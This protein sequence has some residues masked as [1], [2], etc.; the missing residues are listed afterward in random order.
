MMIFLSQVSVIIE[1]EIRTSTYPTRIMLGGRFEDNLV[2]GFD[3]VKLEIELEL[4]LELL[5]SIVRD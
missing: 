5:L 1:T 4:E 3:V 2:A